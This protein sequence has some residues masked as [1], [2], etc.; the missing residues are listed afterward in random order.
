MTDL[1][2]KPPFPF[3]D[4]NDQ[5]LVPIEN[6]PIVGL[7]A[8]AVTCNAAGKTNT[9]KVLTL[10]STALSA[11]VASVPRPIGDRGAFDKVETLTFFLNTHGQFLANHVCKATGNEVVSMLCIVKPKVTRSKPGRS[12]EDR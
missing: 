8:W 11:C 9:T 1:Q 7:V 5:H 4:S 6:R 12:L 3:E 2:L 10:A